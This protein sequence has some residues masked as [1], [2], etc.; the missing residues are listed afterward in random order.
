P[1]LKNELGSF[2]RVKA[3]LVLQYCLP[4][5][6]LIYYGEEIEMDGGNDPENRAPM[7]WQSVSKETETRILYKKLNAIRETK[8]SLRAGN[9]KPLISS[10]SSLISFKRTGEIVDDMV[11]CVVNPT[12]NNVESRVFLQ[13]GFLMNG[14]E[15]KD[16]LTGRAFRVSFG[17][18]SV[19]LGPFEALIM[20]PLIFRSD[21]HYSPYKRL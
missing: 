19:D 14:T 3:A 4:G 12:A 2:Q 7:D 6:P 1:R 5:I 13:E 17:T 18:V 16:L 11:L 21:L 8:A 15:M 20:E 10:D 9:F